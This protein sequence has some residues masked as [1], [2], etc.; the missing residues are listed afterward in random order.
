MLRFNC[1]SAEELAVLET[2]FVSF[3][4]AQS[5]LAPDWVKIKESDPVQ[6]QELIE[7]FSNVVYGSVMSDAQYLEHKTKNALYCYQCLSDRF[8]LI[9]LEIDKKSEFD[10][11]DLDLKKIS[12]IVT[13]AEMHVYTTE[14]AYTK[15]KE[16]EVFQLMKIGCEITD[17]EMFKMLGGML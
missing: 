4:S 2:Q 6:A 12:T 7:D 3:L 16:D 1:L 15:A 14:K 13:N 5:I 9:V 8:V 10:L 17:G 11:R